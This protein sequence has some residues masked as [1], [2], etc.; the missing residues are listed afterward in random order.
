M[1]LMLKCRHDG[2]Y[3]W[4]GAF[5]NGVLSVKSEHGGRWHDNAIAVA[6]LVELMELSIQGRDAWEHLFQVSPIHNVR[7]ARIHLRATGEIVDGL[8]LTCFVPSCD[9]PWA[10]VAGGMLY[11]ESKHEQQH[12][13]TLTTDFVKAIYG[14]FFLG[15]LTEQRERARGKAR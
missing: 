12:V 1:N 8:E 3:Q 13:N 7:P 9:R 4:W 5:Y 2:C 14:E 10:Y 6:T 11:V 15:Q